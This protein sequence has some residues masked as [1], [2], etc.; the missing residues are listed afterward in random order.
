[1][2]AVVQ[3]PTSRCLCLDLI[4]Q[5]HGGTPYH[6]MKPLELDTGGQWQIPLRVSDGWSIGCPGSWERAL[7][8]MDISWRGDDRGWPVD[9]LLGLVPGSI[10]NGMVRLHGSLPSLWEPTYVTYLRERLRLR[11]IIQDTSSKYMQNFLI[12]SLLPKFR[13]TSKL[14]KFQQK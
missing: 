6:T 8:E 3:L 10:S 1:M 9:D 5:A 2:Y 13:S 4:K 12:N 11:K 7:V 14:I